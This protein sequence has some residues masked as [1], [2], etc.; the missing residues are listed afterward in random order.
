[1]RKIIKKT[2]ITLKRWIKKWENNI[3]LFILYD[4]KIVCK[5]LKIIIFKL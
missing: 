4:I 5:I 1:M 3:V 2:Y